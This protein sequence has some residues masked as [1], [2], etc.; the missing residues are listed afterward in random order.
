M[1]NL[2]GTCI[3]DQIVNK[4]ETACIIF[5]NEQ[6]IAFLDHRPLF[7]GHTLI[8]PSK[9]VETLYDLPEDLIGD[10]FKLVKSIGKA[11]ELGM[12]AAGSFIAMNNT[13]SQSIP[14][15]HVHAIPRNKGD[16]LKGFFWPRSRYLNEEH[17]LQTQEQIKRALVQIL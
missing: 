16:G 9:H 6:F 7:P 10:F 3:I 12:N 4:K 1:A 8:S 5:E 15:L 14:H 11:V 17:M 2:K 13:I